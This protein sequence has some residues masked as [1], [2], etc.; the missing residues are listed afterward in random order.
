MPNREDLRE[1]SDDVLMA[2]TEAREAAPDDRALLRLWTARYP[3]CADTLIAVDYARFAAGMTLGDSVE[4]GLEDAGAAAIGR[5]ALAAWRAAS[6]SSA[7]AP[8][9]AL[10][11]LVSDAAA[12]GL[13]AARLAEVLRLDRLLL[14]RLEQRLLDAATLPRR[15]VQ[16]IAQIL[17]RSPDEVASY[18][19]GSPRVAAQAHFRARRAPSLSSS[20]ERSSFAQALE[21]SHNLSE[22]DRA[23]WQ[24]EIEAGVLG[25]LSTSPGNKFP[26]S[27]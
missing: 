14:G 18:L 23:Y 10:T 4:D 6:A 7:A 26:P 22:A 24:A 11:S 19:R 2:F 20:A 21:V 27:P 16:Q 17:E 15:L 5:E 8:R 13:D 3:D 25:E 9:P 1:D 12:R